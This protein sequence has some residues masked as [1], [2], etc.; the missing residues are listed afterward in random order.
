MRGMSG[1]SGWRPVRRS[2]RCT[3]VI[4]DQ[5]DDAGN[6]REWPALDPGGVARERWRGKGKGS[7]R[8]GRASAAAECFGIQK[9]SFNLA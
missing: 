5:S 6:L 7:Q 8:V 4:P 9:F 2:A 3:S 1:D